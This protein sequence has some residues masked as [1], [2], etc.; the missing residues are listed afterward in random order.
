MKCF[1]WKSQSF[2]AVIIQFLFIDPIIMQLF[3]SVFV[4]CT[5]YQ[6]LGKYT[7]VASI[8]ALDVAWLASEAKKADFK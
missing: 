6:Q 5:I 8:I 7:Y 4:C 3:E 2:S 1:W